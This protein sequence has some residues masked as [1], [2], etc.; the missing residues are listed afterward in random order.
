MQKHEKQNSWVHEKKGKSGR[1]GEKGMYS[2]YNSILKAYYHVHQWTAFIIVIIMKHQLWV[3]PNIEIIIILG[4]GWR[5]GRGS[6]K[7]QKFSWQIIRKW[8][9]LIMHISTLQETVVKPFKAFSD[10]LTFKL[11]AY[12][13]LSGDGEK[14]KKVEGR[15]GRETVPRT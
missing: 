6:S 11:C 14:K 10:G 7:K 15:R 12:I 9:K 1:V 5:K 4:A 3:K 2:M 8:L 13:A